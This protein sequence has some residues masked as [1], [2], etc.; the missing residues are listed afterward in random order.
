MA[1]I[2]VTVPKSFGLDTWIAE[3]DPAGTEWSGE[4]WDYT[5]WGAKPNINPGE[6]VYVVYNGCIRG[7]APLVELD[8]Y[9]GEIILT[10]GGNAVAVTVPEKVVGFRGWRYRWWD[11]SAEQ[12]FPDWQNPNAKPYA[13]RG[14]VADG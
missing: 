8:Y 10:R 11:L 7:Y 13:G 5:T 6:R 14:E 1:D 4:H 9:R 12:P 2:V 3:G